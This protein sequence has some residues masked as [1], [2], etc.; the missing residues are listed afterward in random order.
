MSIER[1]INREPHPGLILATLYFRKPY[2]TCDDIDF[3]SIASMRLLEEF[4]YPA[5]DGYGKF[6]VAYTRRIPSGE[7]SFT[8]G[9]AI[10]LTCSDGKVLSKSEVYAHI[11]QY[12]AEKAEIYDGA[13][14]SSL[15]IRVYIECKKDKKDR[16]LLSDE[17]IV[18]TLSSL[19]QAGKME[20]EPRTARKIRH[21][22][23]S[24]PTPH[25]TALKQSRTQM[26]PF[27]VADTETIL[28][29]D[30]HKPYAAGLLMVRPGEDLSS[31]V[32]GIET[33][34]SED[35][36]IILDSFEERSTKV[37][38]DLIER[39]STIARQEKS[40]LTVYF[41]NFSRFDGILLLKHLSCHHECYTLKPLMRNHRLYELVVYHGK[42]KLFRFRDS[43]NLLPSSLANLAKNLCP[44]LGSKGSIPYE[45][46]T[47][48]NLVSMK[49][50]LLD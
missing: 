9:P 17:D 29:D 8:I 21:L 37:F 14:I 23:R 50:S 18:S 36:S 42:K 44:D 26:K 6:T 22:K 12:L 35:Y 16:P 41:H 15:S 25:I 13:E 47:L 40:I 28:I 27:L 39:I 48:S 30:V 3:L 10:P 38:F 5:L 7:V 11:Y 31:K 1:K 33:Y 24:Y 49:T 2:P 20:I 32:K 4:A 46:V 43:L 19:L 34:F 45:D